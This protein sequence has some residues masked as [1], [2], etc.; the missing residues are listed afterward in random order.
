VKDSRGVPVEELL[1]PHRVFCKQPEE[2]LVESLLTHR[3][4]FNV[5]RHRVGQ[6]VVHLRLI[7]DV[8]RSRRITDN[9]GYVTERLGG[10]TR[11]LVLARQALLPLWPYRDLGVHGVSAGEEVTSA[12]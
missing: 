2:V 10:R 12:L 4:H 7:S 8:P 9:D 3:P 5:K 11:P 1:T 6:C